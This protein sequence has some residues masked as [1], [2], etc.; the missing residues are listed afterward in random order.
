MEASEPSTVMMARYAQVDSK[1][2]IMRQDPPA[3]PVAFIAISDFWA[4]AP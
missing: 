4:D 2:Y 1:G 3:D